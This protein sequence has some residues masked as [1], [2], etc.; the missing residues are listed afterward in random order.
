LSSGVVKASNNYE[1]H[2]TLCN[3]PESEQHAMPPEHQAVGKVLPG[4]L[5]ARN[6][7]KKVF[8][9]AESVRDDE[10]LERVRDGLSSGSRL[11]VNSATADACLT[12]PTA[13]QWVASSWSS[14]QLLDETDQQLAA[15][16]IM[17]K[18]NSVIVRCE[19]RPKGAKGENTAQQICLAAALKFLGCSRT[20]MVP[21]LYPEQHDTEAGKQAVYKLLGR[22]AVWIE[23]ECLDMNENLAFKIVKT[24][25][26]KEIADRIVK[27]VL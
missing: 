14:F 21:F 2:Y 27:S 20:G 24:S 6:I 8:D 13:K 1:V 26:T 11:R 12:T 4:S 15:L 25:V 17:A 16:E 22:H 23:Q 3:R 19:G 9:C 5:T 18:F 7:L 10:I